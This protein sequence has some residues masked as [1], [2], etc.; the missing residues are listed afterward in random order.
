MTK[1]DFYL[2]KGES[3]DPRYNLACRLT[4][5]AILKNHS[6]FIYCENRDACDAL[7]KQLWTFKPESF[8][9]HR[10]IQSGDTQ[11]S[12]E[13]VLIAHDFEPDGNISVLINL[14]RSV[15]Y[16]FSRFER[17]LEIIN[18]DNEVKLNGR[19]RWSFYKKRGYPIKHHTISL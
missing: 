4:E 3:I 16:F 13:P 14:S 11:S 9:A 15:P 10:V 18:E 17:T 7:D 5:K 6:V 19:T 1:I 12:E 8:V 2:L